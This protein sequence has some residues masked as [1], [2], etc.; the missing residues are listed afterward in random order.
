METTFYIAGTV[1]LAL[2]LICYGKY[3]NREKTGKVFHPRNACDESPNAKKRALLYFST[4][5]L[6]ATSGMLCN[7]G[8]KVGTYLGT[9]SCF[10]MFG[11]VILSFFM[12]KRK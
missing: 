10:V 8:S 5:G 6:F 4:A 2:S 1:C 9:V 12:H 11:I 7:I 3:V